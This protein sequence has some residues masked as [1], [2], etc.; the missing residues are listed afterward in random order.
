MSG[1]SSTQASA[2]RSSAST[3]SYHIAATF[4]RNALNGYRTIRSA[5][6]PNCRDHSSSNRKF[7]LRSVEKTRQ[8]QQLRKPGG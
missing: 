1:S 3:D 7:S 4:C 2:L 6:Q 5:D 8:T